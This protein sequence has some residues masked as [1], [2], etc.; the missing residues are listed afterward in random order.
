VQS[1]SCWLA[2]ELGPCGP[3]DA[4]ACSMFRAITC[5]R[6]GVIFP[7]ATAWS[8]DAWRA[9]LS[10]AF[11]YSDSHLKVPAEDGSVVD[12]A[13][14]ASALVARRRQRAAPA[15]VALARRPD[16]DAPRPS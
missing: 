5:A 9:C 16:A 8:S 2:P 13:R 15:R 6:S 4:C 3:A 14:R 12:N 7:S 10:L 11:E 1:P